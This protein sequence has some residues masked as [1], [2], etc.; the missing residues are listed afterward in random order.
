MKKSILVLFIAVSAQLIQ[1]QSPWTKEKGR[2][3]VQLGVS[4]LF[5]DK[6]QIDGEKITLGADYTDVT[7]QL[8]T[9]YGITDN[10]EAL[11]IVPVKF[12]SFESKLTNASGSISGLGNLTFG[13]KYK[14]YDHK[15]KISTGL[16]FQANTSKKD[17]TNS[18]STDFNAATFIPYLSVGSSSGKWYYFGNI[19]YGYMTN[20]YSDYLKFAAELGYNIIPKGHLILALDTKNPVAKESAFENNTSKWPSYLDRQTYNAFGLKFNYEFS[21][22]KYGANIATFG[23][24]GNDNAPLAPSINFAVYAKL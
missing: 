15:W 14:V 10:L 17:V 20:D 5:Y 18:L 19:G 11:L 8:Y 9:E 21:K 3:Y 7:T 22:D 24:F 2:A 12:A 16:Q 23:A 1:A 13:L 6:A 4:G